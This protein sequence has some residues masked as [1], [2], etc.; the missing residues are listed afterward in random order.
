MKSRLLAFAAMALALTTPSHDALAVKVAPEPEQM[1]A[2][3]IVTVRK[4]MTWGAGAR[5]S[6]DP[7]VVFVSCHGRPTIDGHGCDAYRGDTAC[8]VKLPVLCLAV[9]G[10]S[11]PDGIETP[12]SGGVMQAGFYSGWAQ[13]RVALAPAVRGD[14]FE[15]RSDANAWCAAKL[16]AGWRVAEHH[17]SVGTDGAHGGWGLVANGRIR[18]D[19]RFWVAIND[20][21]A[22]CWDASR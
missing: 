20:T 3:A 1:A 22:N 12:P 13:G 10:R 9:D 8:S 17:D 5:L 19:A 18:D 6:A 4:G 21:A 15:R 14:A 2:P 7:K 16:G 11:R